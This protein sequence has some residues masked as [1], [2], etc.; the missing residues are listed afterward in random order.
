MR[1]EILI[2]FRQINTI[3]YICIDGRNKKKKKERLTQRH[4]YLFEKIIQKKKRYF[5]PRFFF[6]QT[7]LIISYTHTQDRIQPTYVHMSSSVREEKQKQQSLL[8]KN[9]TSAL[10]TVAAVAGAAAVGAAILERKYDLST[11]A[12]LM[13]NIMFGPLLNIIRNRGK[14]FT[15]ADVWELARSKVPGSKV[16]LINAETGESF[17]FD[18]I[19]EYS[20]RVANWALSTGMKSRDVC[21]LFME[22]RPQYIMTWLGLCKIGVIIA[23]INSNNKR[24]TLLHALSTGHCQ[25]MIFGSELSGVV[26]DV[27]SSLSI[28]LIA[29]GPSCPPFATHLQSALRTASNAP[30]SKKK[31]RAGITTK[32]TFGY[33]YTSGTTGLPKACIMTNEK[34]MIAGVFMPVYIGIN[35]NDVLYTALPLYHSAGGMLGVGVF[36]LGCTAVISKK[37]SATNFFRHCAKYNATCVQYIGELARYLMN[38]KPGDWDTKHKVRVAFGNGM[39]SEVWVPF[40]KRFRIPEIG[41]FYGATEGNQSFVNHVKTTDFVDFPGAG[42]CGKIG[43]LFKMLRGEPTIIKHDAATEM[44]VRDPK[45][46]LCIPCARGE[47]GELV[48]LIDPNI[49]FDG[50]TNKEATAKKILTGVLQKGDKYFRTGDLARYTPEGYVYFVD[51]VGDTFRWK[52]ENVSTGEVAAIVGEIAGVTEANIY[53]VKVPSSQDGRAC[54]AAITTVNNQTPNL[55]VFLKHVDENLA[56]YQRPLFVRH[57]PEMESTG[58]FKQRK[59]TFVKEGMDPSVV[60]DPMWWYNP[61][62]KK[63][64]V[65]D[66]QAYQTLV[67]GRAR[68]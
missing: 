61:A 67:L 52:G 9:D 30:I 55:E 58:T 22:N 41:E 47:P 43:L 1:G 31:H 26:A 4:V 51:R 14:E 42:A 37:F 28:P 19:E 56:T 2:L 32:D 36:M 39:R 15:E 3:L 29:A 68:M 12:V 13:K 66:A 65:L 49:A 10:G 24:K 8:V 57:L 33:I 60:K 40:Q 17:T 27:Q 45:T 23:L 38:A 16:G 62:A 35:Q 63:Y 20:N 7:L 54:M 59:V 25:A 48:G 53:G 11:E 50:Y 6:S 5:A 64:E 21:G 34:F 46:G 44:P 18:Q